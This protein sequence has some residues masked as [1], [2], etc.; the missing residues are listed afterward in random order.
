MNSEPKPVSSQHLAS[1]FYGLC[2][3]GPRWQ[4]SPGEQKALDFLERALAE[5]LRVEFAKETFPYLSFLPKSARLQTL[6]GPKKDIACEALAYSPSMEAEGELVFVPEAA[7]PE[8]DVF[9]KIVLTDAVRSYLAYPVVRKGGALGLVLG[10]HLPGNLLR[11]GVT[12]YEGR[13][14]GI[15]AV[16]VGAE[17]TARLKDRAQKGTR[18][19]MEVA[20]TAGRAEGVNLVVRQGEDTGRGRMLVCSHYDSMWLGPHANDNATGTAAVLELIRCFKDT[21]HGLTFLLC[22]GEELGFW[23]SRAFAGGHDEECRALQAILCTDALS[24]NQGPVE[25]GVTEALAPTLRSLT[26]QHGVSVG[27]W[28]IPPR[29]GSDHASFASFEK[30]TVWLTTNS[31]Y[32]HTAADVPEHVDLDNLRLHT[33][34]A[35]DIITSIQGLA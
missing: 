12:S 2:D 11:A 8:A 34:L 9:E 22:G 29:P 35:R 33:A 28:N 4:G 32:Y 17:D 30:P 26:R 25:I 10:N 20:A 18:I 27:T 7:L 21:P 16:A 15:P 19:R 5:E 13:L 24:S 3:L 31:P 14:G 23:G 1:V 6:T